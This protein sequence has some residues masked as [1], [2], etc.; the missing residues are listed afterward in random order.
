MTT[1]SIFVHLGICF[2]DFPAVTLQRLEH[3]WSNKVFKAFSV[4]LRQKTKGMIDLCFVK[5]FPHAFG[6]DSDGTQF[7]QLLLW[8][9]FL[10]VTSSKGRDGCRNLLTIG[11]LVLVNCPELGSI[12][13]SLLSPMLQNTQL[14]MKPALEFLSFCQWNNPIEVYVKNFCVLSTY[15]HGIWLPSKTFLCKGLNYLVKSC[16]PRVEWSLVKFINFT[17]CLS[18]SSYTMAVISENRTPPTKNQL[19]PGAKINTLTSTKDPCSPWVFSHEYCQGRPYISESPC[20]SKSCDGG[21]SCWVLSWRLTL[22]LLS[23]PL[24]HLPCL[25]KLPCLCLQSLRL[26]STVQACLKN[27][28]WSLHSP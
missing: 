23:Q 2:N 3:Q 6:L 21:S 7:L 24:T 19:S 9:N 27:Q 1:R 18:G 25:L 4:P 11:L 20:W 26:S 5:R 16:L 12:P 22:S 13:L 10:I 28:P 17:L 15:F 8:A 14:I